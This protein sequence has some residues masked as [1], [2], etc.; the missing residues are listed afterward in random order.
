MTNKTATTKATIPATYTDGGRLGRLGRL[1]LM[2]II[3]FISNDASIYFQH[4]T[5]WGTLAPS[6]RGPPT[7]PRATSDCEILTYS[8][9]Q[10]PAM[11]WH[12]SEQK[13]LMGMPA[14][15]CP[16]KPMICSSVNLVFF[17]SVILQRLTDFVP[18]SWY[19]LEGAGQYDEIQHTINR[20]VQVL[21]GFPLPD[22]FS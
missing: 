14:S 2:R 6:Q 10:E 3:S 12:I 16:R 1:I 19:G 18:F 5:L 17:M 9:E 8:S 20:T 15:A 7:V 11:P 13:A 21:G 22:D 4:V